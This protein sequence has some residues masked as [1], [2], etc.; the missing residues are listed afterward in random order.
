MKDTE[1]ML[2][3]TILENN[4]K[5]EDYSIHSS[6]LLRTLGCFKRSKVVATFQVWKKVNTYKEYD[7]VYQTLDKD[8]HDNEEWEVSVVRA[9]E[10]V[11]VHLTKEGIECV[12]EEVA[13]LFT[14]F[15]GEG[16]EDKPTTNKDENGKF[17]IRTLKFYE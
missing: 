15:P 14:V 3:D 11:R 6:I 8:I 16:V 7:W 2:E 17:Y 4:K 10:K 13:D 1:M 12:K 5:G 9:G